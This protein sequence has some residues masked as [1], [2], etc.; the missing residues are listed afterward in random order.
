VSF[1]IV[2]REPSAGGMLL[3]EEPGP[4]KTSSDNVHTLEHVFLNCDHHHEPIRVMH[5]DSTLKASDGASD[6]LVHLNY[7]IVLRLPRD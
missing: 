7:C 1:Q 4:A 3:A 6:I 5:S 2:V